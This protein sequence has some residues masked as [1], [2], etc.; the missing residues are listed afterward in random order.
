M[1][2]TSQCPGNDQDNH[3]FANTPDSA[4]EGRIELPRC[5]N[6]AVFIGPPFFEAL[7]HRKSSVIEIRPTAYATALPY[8][9]GITWLQLYIRAYTCSLGPRYSPHSTST[10]RS[11]NGISTAS[12]ICVFA[13]SRTHVPLL[14]EPPRMRRRFVHAASAFPWPDT[15]KLWSGDE[16]GCEKWLTGSPGVRYI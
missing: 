12:S 8:H 13:R 3:R 16:R 7:P 15:T 6:V 4:T 10:S 5:R 1:R 11:T 14:Q 9:P 2:P